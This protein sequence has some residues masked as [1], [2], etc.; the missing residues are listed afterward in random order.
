MGGF[1]LAPSHAGVALVPTV[2]LK[3]T[4]PG[5][6]P[7]L[8]R[9]ATLPESVCVSMRSTEMSAPGVYGDCPRPWGT[10]YSVPRHTLPPRARRL[11]QAPRHRRE[12]RGPRRL[13]RRPRRSRLGRRR[14]MARGERS[15]ACASRTQRPAR[16]RRASRRSGQADEQV[17]GETWTAGRSYTVAVARGTTSS[18]FEA[19]QSLRHS[20]HDPDAEQV[21]GRQDPA[22]SLDDGAVADGHSDD[23][24][25]RGGES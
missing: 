2:P 14:A 4:V 18:A 24:R 9:R 25:R 13:T 8:A 3:R 12:R 5:A 11:E 7:V 17:G 21:D 1:T 10:S 23:V 15:V 20:E 22:E 6:P 16:L 19:P